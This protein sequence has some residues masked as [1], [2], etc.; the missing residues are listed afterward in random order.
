MKSEKTPPA[1]GVSEPTRSAAA[2]ARLPRPVRERQ[3]LEAASDLFGRLGYHA[4]SMDQIAD[5][6]G[7]SKPMLYAYFDSKEGLCAACLKRAGVDAI[8]AIGTSYEPGLTPEQTLWSGLLAFFEFVSRE[9]SSWKLIRSQAS[10]DVGVFQSMVREIHDDIRS[11]IEQ[12]AATASRETA[13]DPFADAELRAG[14]AH[15]LFGAASAMADRGLDGDC[16]MPA[17]R[18][19]TELMDFFWVGVRALADGEQWRPLKSS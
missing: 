3:M 15:A 5:S 2:R 13:G 1:T 14:F 9:P 18:Y 12:L 16:A 11:V 7:I 10:Y 4:V 6:V 8:N 19:A 17:D